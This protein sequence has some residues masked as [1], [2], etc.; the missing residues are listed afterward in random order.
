[1]IRAFT[2]A[3]L[4]SKLELHADTD[5]NPLI[6]A[7]DSATAGTTTLADYL[8]FLAPMVG[9]LVADRP[10]GNVL[11]QAIGARSLAA[12]VELD[13]ADVA[14]APVWEEQL[15]GGNIVTV[16]YQADQGASVTVQDDASIGRYG[17]RPI[18]IDTAFQNASDATARGNERLYRSA[19]THWEMPAAPILRGLDLELGAPVILSSLPPAAPFDPWTPL[20][21]GWT[22]TISGEAWTMEL[23]LSD[24]LISGLT[25][26]WSSVPVDPA[27][28][29]NTIDQATAWIDALTLEDLDAG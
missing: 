20:V 1:V 28:H 2:E 16:T 22:D 25:L 26:P 10:N 23:A 15:P 27:Y 29:W 3:G 12:A 7:R 5:F 11:V 21:E 13:P 4:A 19:Y 9:A 8:S 6:S 24:P 14:Y 17:K 18:T